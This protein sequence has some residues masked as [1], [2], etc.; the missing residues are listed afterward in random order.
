MYLSK[1]ASFKELCET[2]TKVHRQIWL[3]MCRPF[4]GHL[5]KMCGRP[6][7]SEQKVHKRFGSLSL[8]LSV[9]SG[10]HQWGIFRWYSFTLRY[11]SKIWFESR[12]KKPTFFNDCTTLVLLVYKCVSIKVAQSQKYVL[13]RHM[14]RQGSNICQ[15]I[16]FILKC[17]RNISIPLL[18]HTL[19]TLMSVLTLKVSQ[20]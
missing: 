5:T 3:L 20:V 19:T 2:M 13:V 10:Q 14:T 6:L 7:L 11:T 18:R 17:R 15:K 12:K 1:S 16:P 8:H 9:K 4:Q